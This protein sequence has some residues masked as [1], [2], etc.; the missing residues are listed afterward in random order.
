[1][2]VETL[3]HF[4]HL[5]ID[6]FLSIA[7]HAAVERGVDFQTIGIRVEL[8]TVFLDIFSNRLAEIEGFAVV[9]TLNTEIKFQ[10][11]F[12]KRIELSLC[13]DG[14]VAEMFLHF[15]TMLIDIAEHEIASFETTLGIDARIIGRRGFEQADQHCRFLNLEF[16]R[17]FVEI[18]L[19]SRF[20]AKSVRPEINGVGI[21]H[22][23]AIFLVEHLKLHGN[24]HF[25]RLH[26]HDANAGNLAN[27]ARAVL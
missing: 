8:R 23:D 18:G 16:R 7:L 22:Q 11:R 12:Q 19:S 6:S 4:L 21:H 10:R 13:L 25:L 15:S 1:M 20:D 24:G 3:L 27:E 2:V 17:S 5:L 9:S 26:N 14:S